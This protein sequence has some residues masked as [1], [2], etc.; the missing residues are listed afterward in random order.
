MS[1]DRDTRAPDTRFDVVDSTVTHEGVMSTLR[2]D[3][4]AMPGGRL[5]S[6][7]VAQRPD[8]VAVV[9]LT[10]D[11]E[12]VMVR[13]YRHPVGRY[14]LE[15][16]AGLL[17]VEGE[18]EADAAQRELAEEVGM[19][20]GTLERLTRFLNSAGWTDEATT[21]FVGRDLRPATPDDDF[22]AEAEEADMEV[23]RVPLAEAVALVRTGAVTD[24]KTVIGLLLVGCDARD[25]L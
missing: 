24:A 14:E 4:V 7:E 10:D 2:V 21:L 5:A 22:V 16:P 20:A 9:P 8:A 12:V 25:D 17:D 3:R 18:A 11:G 23:L 19:T 13:Q 15:I 6:R 1:D